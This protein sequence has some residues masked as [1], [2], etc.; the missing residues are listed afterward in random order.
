MK[1]LRVCPFCG[2]EA[3]LTAEVSFKFNKKTEEYVP[4][5]FFNYAVICHGCLTKSDFDFTKSS[6][7]TYWNMQRDGVG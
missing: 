5:K 3:Y 4:G 7:V 1:K 2:Q 6:A